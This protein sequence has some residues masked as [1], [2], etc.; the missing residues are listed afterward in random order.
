MR[1]LRKT[2]ELEIYSLSRRICTL[3]YNY[4]IKGT[5][6]LKIWPIQVCFIY[7]EF[8]AGEETWNGGGVVQANCHH[9]FTTYTFKRQ[10]LKIA[11]KVIVYS[12][13][14]SP[15]VPCPTKRCFFFFY[16]CCCCCFLCL[17]EYF[18]AY[19]YGNWFYLSLMLSSWYI[20]STFFIHADDKY[21]RM[22]SYI[23]I[24][25]RVILI[26]INKS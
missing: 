21:C 17:L 16:L 6:I 7:S 18:F 10:I 20:V 13:P 15:L 4:I 5:P 26:L 12:V 9:P 25:D 11:I 8:F 2:H 1:C 3:N 24:E 19:I 22:W 23:Y 14:P